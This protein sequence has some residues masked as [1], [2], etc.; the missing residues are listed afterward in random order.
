MRTPAH[1]EALV[2]LLS[3]QRRYV[4]ITADPWYHVSDV[5]VDGA[6]VGP[7][8]SYTFQNVTSNHTISATLTFIND[9]AIPMQS[10]S[11]TT[12]ATRLIRRIR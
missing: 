7:T 11:T 2:R 12:V 3:V 1:V 5:E 4:A 6:P 8:N 10:S 9:Q